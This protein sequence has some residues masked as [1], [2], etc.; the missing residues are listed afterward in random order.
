MCSPESADDDVEALEATSGYNQRLLR[1]RTAI[2]FAAAVAVAMLPS[3]LLLGRAGWRRLCRG[4]DAES[5]KKARIARYCGGTASSATMIMIGVA[6]SSGYSSARGRY[7]C[8]MIGI[9]T[10]A[11]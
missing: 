4:A 8:I 2:A 1:Q 10:P 7:S 6:S 9:M 11:S 3:L 5:T